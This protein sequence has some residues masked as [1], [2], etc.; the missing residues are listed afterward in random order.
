MMTIV[1]FLVFAAA[2]VTSL[3]VMV[4]TLAPAMPRIM[5]L[6]SRRE[7]FG[8]CPQLVLR[9]RR[10]PSRGRLVSPIPPNQARRAAA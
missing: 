10:V 8:T 4:Y 2:L 9:D 6:L 5:A 1:A 7:E 3:A